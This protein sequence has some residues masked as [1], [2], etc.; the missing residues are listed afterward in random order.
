MSAIVSSKKKALRSNKKNITY[1]ID[2][3]DKGEIKNP[4]NS[5]EERLSKYS[6]EAAKLLVAIGEVLRV[7]YGTRVSTILE[8]PDFQKPHITHEHT[9]RAINKWLSVHSNKIVND[10][11][12]RYVKHLNLSGTDIRSA[13]LSNGKIDVC[14]KL[15]EDLSEV[16]EG[17]TEDRF[18]MR[19]VFYL[20]LWSCICDTN[21]ILVGACILDSAEQAEKK[22]SQGPSPMRIDDAWDL[23]WGYYKCS[24]ALATYTFNKSC[25]TQVE[26]Y[27]I[28]FLAS[29]LSPACMK[30]T[31][32][33]SLIPPKQPTQMI[34]YMDP[35]LSEAACS[36]SWLLFLTSSLICVTSDEV[37]CPDRKMNRIT[38]PSA[39]LKRLFEMLDG[40]IFP[41]ALHVAIDFFKKFL[42]D[43]NVCEMSKKITGCILMQPRF[44]D[45]WQTLPHI[46]TE[47][48]PPKLSRSKIM[49]KNNVNTEDETKAKTVCIYSMESKARGTAKSDPAMERL[50][51]RRDKQTVREMQ[52][53][54]GK[55]EQNN[56]QVI[57]KIEKEIQMEVENKIGL[58]EEME[59]S[60][61]TI[62]NVA[63]NN[64]KEVKRRN[65][66]FRNVK[67]TTFPRRT[68]DTVEVAAKVGDGTEETCQKVK[69]SNSSSAEK[70][71][72]THNE[73]QS[74]RKKGQTTKKAQK[75]PVKKK[76]PIKRAPVR[77]TM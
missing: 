76:S 18:K 8:D 58:E 74:A 55:E 20:A 23:I 49:T 26:E 44:S 69:K 41:N 67:V 37:G 25:F 1:A 10:I 22:M 21:F 6:S 11:L 7:S 30:L 4:R 61:N 36:H 14:P 70:V 9:I 27:K 57:R 12:P 75:Q 56:D 52:Q 34:R 16:L 51:M 65:D 53:M 5:F 19:A 68:A 48:F 66:N 39:A 64:V 24:S 73:R 42:A 71:K 47:A 72:V 3:Q 60:N 77:H 15:F 29:G 33:I 40:E 45:I 62:S 13:I 63:R 50:N 28:F 31:N 2:D 46:S 17:V 54:S 38:P 59:K 35:R 43:F 32:I